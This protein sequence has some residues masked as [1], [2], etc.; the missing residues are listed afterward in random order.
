MNSIMRIFEEIE[1]NKEIS[2]INWLEIEVID[3]ELE[4]LRGIR[5][6]LNQFLNYCKNHDEFK[7]FIPMY[8]M[9]LHGEKH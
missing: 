3:S 8:E 1:H 2:A 6:R 9:I 5:K 4:Y 7:S